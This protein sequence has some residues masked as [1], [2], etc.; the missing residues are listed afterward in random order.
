MAKEAVGVVGIGHM[1]L[2][3]S[4]RLIGA[5]YPVVAYDLA[6]DAMREAVE[7]GAAAADSLDRPRASAARR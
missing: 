3:M 4:R 5:G 6:P 2:P 1:G 7:S